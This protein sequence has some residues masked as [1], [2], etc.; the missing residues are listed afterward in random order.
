[1]KNVLVLGNKGMLGHIVERYF[2]T[3]PD[4]YDV[5][6]INR[7]DGFDARTDYSLAYDYWDYIIDKEVVESEDH[8]QGWGQARRVR[9]RRRKRR[10][11][12]MV[13]G[14][15]RWKEAESLIFT[16][17]KQAARYYTLIYRHI[18]EH[19]EKQLRA[20]GKGLTFDSS[21]SDIPSKVNISGG[22]WKETE[23]RHKKSE[24]LIKKHSAKRRIEQKIEK[25]Q[26]ELASVDEVYQLKFDK[27]EGLYREHLDSQKK[28]ENKI[29]DKLEEAKLK[30]EQGA[31]VYTALAS[32]LKSVRWNV[33]LDHQE[34][35]GSEPSPIKDYLID[36]IGYYG[37][38]FVMIPKN[39]MGRGSKPRIVAASEFIEN[40]WSYTSRRQRKPSRKAI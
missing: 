39:A 12:S 26:Q 34:D 35:Y 38:G 31:S 4:K 24:I 11:K 1:M 22:S 27:N 18:P 5:H 8:H 7:E 16:D 9:A 28:K 17:Y 19:D 30:L 25:A 33:D 2:K 36:L 23:L 20:L 14:P 13:Q 40:I 29:L 6:G 3:M 15:L 10:R 32:F 21:L 37:K